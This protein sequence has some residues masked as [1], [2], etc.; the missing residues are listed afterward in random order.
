[1]FEN[2]NNYF[3]LIIIKG[4]TNHHNIIAILNTIILYTNFLNTTKNI[5]FIDI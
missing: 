1:M 4:P 5:L 3:S 2:T